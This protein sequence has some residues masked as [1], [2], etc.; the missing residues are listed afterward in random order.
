MDLREFFVIIKKLTA[1]KK[2]P[3]ILTFF[4]GGLA[5]NSVAE[6][7]PLTL[8]SAEPES[9]GKG[10]VISFI[11]VSGNKTIS[12]EAILNT[13]STKPGL[14]LDPQTL[15]KDIQTIYGLGY[16]HDVKVTRE[17]Q[18]VISIKVIE[19]PT[20]ADITFNGFDIVSSHSLKDKIVSKK[21][22]IVDEKKI[23]Q[24]LRTIEQTYIEKGYY[25]AKASYVF[26]ETD[27]GSVVLCFKVIEN[28]PIYVRSV[29]FV[30]NEY[31]S[32]AELSNFMATRPFSWMSF[33]SSSGVFKDEF[34][35]TDQQNL[36]YIY[37]ENGYAE[38]TVSAPVGI[39]EKNKS[40]IDV[41]YSIEQGERFHIGK[42]EITGDLIEP[43]EEIKKKL[44]LLENNLYRISK[45]NS[46]MKTLKTIYGDH[47]YAFAYVYPQFTLDRKNKLFNISYNIN[48]GEKAYFGQFFI[49]GNVKT[50]DNVIR[51]QL[52][53]AEG[54]LFNQTNFDKS[55][56][57]INKLGFFDGDVNL[58]QEA[59]KENNKINVRISVKE[60][61]T[62]SLQAS[63]GASPNSSGN[64]G[65]TFFGSG[66]Y[67][68]KNLFG[69]AYAIS[70]NVQLSPSPQS[71]N[72]LNYTLG[73][74]FTNPSIFDGPWGYG[75]SVSYQKQV[76]SISTSNSIAQ[77][78]L[79]QKTLTESGFI[80]REIIENLRFNMGYSFA[81]YDISPSVPLTA[82][83]FQSGRTEELT[84]ALVY[85]ATDNNLDPTEGFYGNA[86]NALAVQVFAGQYN[87]GKS[88]LNLAYY[89]P[90]SYTEN[91][92][93]NFKF[94]F[95]P[96]YVYPT[97]G[98]ETIPYWKRLSLGN[99]YFMKGYS[100]PGE[101]IGPSIPVAISPI[102]GQVIPLIYGGNRSLYS[103]I[104]YFIPIIAE[105]GL[106]FVSFG[107]AG[108][109][110][111]ESDNFVLS[112]VKYDIGFGFRWKSPVAPFRFEWAFPINDGQIGKAHFVFTIGSDSF[113]AGS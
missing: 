85:D 63:I 20:I 84:Q 50:R 51:R 13:I 43:Q 42:I 91:Y 106:R 2:F 52:K 17:S 88:S 56:E 34:T 39:F 89:F 21:Y 103:S 59:D 67:Q 60:K 33:F 113:G 48:K 77:A 26:E 66:Q 71:S 10:E 65:V 25:L 110:L 70:A 80:G 40:D 4:L 18:G 87:Y 6:S 109:V 19:K 98:A 79:T 111:A 75:L 31:F 90:I 108:A 100:S 62:G 97:V 15:A 107:E 35:L 94:T 38:A 12:T 61:G 82:K 78:F 3:W 16:F 27:T 29:N 44:S 41:T 57:R 101:S 36:T 102:S 83:F 68:E 95:I 49:E 105:A 23:S 11:K 14:S 45:F 7:R 96:Q 8:L 54:E 93:T 58:V 30:G 9:L 47:G 81:D 24:D 76:Q 74:N 72:E 73:L 28:S 112:N 64:S 1:K 86:T 99:S 92:K 53:I 55:K 104:E 46:D 22:T 5:I 69:K 32:D 37:R